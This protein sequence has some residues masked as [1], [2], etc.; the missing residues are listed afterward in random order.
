MSA[1]A[2]SGAAF[3]GRK[4][5]AERLSER[6]GCRS[7]DDNVLAEKAAAFGMSHEELRDA[8]Q[9]APSAWDHRKAK[10]LAC[11]DAIRAALLDELR[12]GKTVYHGNAGQLLLTEPG[13]YLRV[14]VAVPFDF[15]VSMVRDR[16]RFDREEA[17]SHLRELDRARDEWIRRLSNI[18]WEDP[19]LYNVAINLAHIDTAEASDAVCSMAIRQSSR[20][21]FSIRQTALDNLALGSRVKVARSLDSSTRGRDPK[22]TPNGEHVSIQGKVAS[23]EELAKVRHLA[24][25]IPG[26]RDLDLSGIEITNSGSLSVRF[27]RLLEHSL[28]IP[29][30]VPFGLRPGW[31]TK[32]FVFFGF[33]YS[34]SGDPM[35]TTLAKSSYSVQCLAGDINTTICH[36]DM[37][38]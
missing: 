11:L 13:P 28:R 20:S 32:D 12:S 15:R 2:I 9:R 25:E 10:K 33:I 29:T 30:F 3:R 36:G 14:R 5:L 26:V 27:V 16:L 35:E 19:S 37:N 8:L 24:R 31:L 6:L 22:I 38:G 1:I 7:T 21:S 17:S 18:A 23:S 4:L 34:F